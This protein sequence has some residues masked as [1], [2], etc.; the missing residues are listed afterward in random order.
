MDDLDDVL[1]VGCKYQRRWFASEVT[2]PTGI[3]GWV[4]RDI[5]RPFAENLATTVSVA[6]YPATLEIINA[7][8]VIN[9]RDL[10][11]PPVRVA[12]PSC[13]PVSLAALVA[14]MDRALHRGLEDDAVYWAEFLQTHAPEPFA[15]A[16]RT[17][18]R[19]RDVIR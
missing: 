17:A 14:G 12:M 8:Y 9:G 6:G 16:L 11:E 3:L 13:P 10:T 7:R 1:H 5:L 4:D 2:V 19:L 18:H 15:E